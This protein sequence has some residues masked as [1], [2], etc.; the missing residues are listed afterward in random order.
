LL[1]ETGATV[2]AFGPGERALGATDLSQQPELSLVY[3][4]DG[5]EFFRVS[6]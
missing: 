1:S 2:V 3:E 6:R 5:V 4:R